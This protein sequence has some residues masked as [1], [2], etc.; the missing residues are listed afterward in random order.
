MPSP[1]AELW[2]AGVSWRNVTDIVTVPMEAI[3]TKTNLKGVLVADPSRAGA[4]AVGYQIK[5]SY[6]SD[7]DLA[8]L[9]ALFT[10]DTPILISSKV[11]NLAVNERTLDIFEGEYAVVELL[12]TPRKN[13]DGVLHDVT[14]SFKCTTPGPSL[15]PLA[16][17]AQVVIQTLGF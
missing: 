10:T 15:T 11:G 2:V 16:G 6:C 3:A 14:L 4:Q 7:A 12:H 1:S 17:P 9:R 5:F 8:A 13:L